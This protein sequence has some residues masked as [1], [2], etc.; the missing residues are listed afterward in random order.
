MKILIVDDDKFVLDAVGAMLTQAGHPVLKVPNGRR[1]M[2]V[3]RQ[4]VPDLVITDIR[5]PVISG[6]DLCRTIKNLHPDLPV[7]G[8]SGHITDNPEEDLF[9]GFLPKPFQMVDLIDKVEEVR[10][11]RAWAAEIKS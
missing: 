6:V 4:R 5:M 1:A 9:D 2:E 3:L 11:K 8:M 7:I 10:Q